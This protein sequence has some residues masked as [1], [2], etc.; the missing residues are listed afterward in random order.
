MPA[1]VRGADTVKAQLTAIFAN[2][3]GPMTEKC[4]TEVL[5][6]GGGRADVMTPIATGNLV[7]SRYREVRRTAAG[8]VGRFGY[9]ADYAAAV[10]SLD[11]KLKGQPRSG[12]NSFSAR[13]GREAF[14]Y[15]KGNFWDPRG[16]P[17][18][19]TKGFEW[20]IEEIRAVVQRSMQI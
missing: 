8:W 16:E 18:W 9:T 1:K 6:V 15:R 7:N 10:H 17:Q 19:L 3:K 4:I 5:I 2:I 12:V 20:S 13:G 11:A 14:A